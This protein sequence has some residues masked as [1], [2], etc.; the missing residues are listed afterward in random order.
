RQRRPWTLANGSQPASRCHSYSV[1]VARKSAVSWSA[2]HETT[3]SAMSMP[4]ETPDDVQNFPS[5]TQRA[6]F[7]QR[8]AGQ[9]VWGTVKNILLVVARGPSSS[10]AW[11]RSEV[12]VHTVM[13]TS[14]CAARSLS[15]AI[16]R[17]F[18]TSARVPIPPG[19]RRRS[20]GGQSVRP[21]SACT[22][23]PCALRT[24]PACSATVTT[25]ILP[26]MLPD[27]S[28]GPKRSSTS[29]SW[30]SS[31]PSVR[32]MAILLGLDATGLRARPQGH[33][34]RTSCRRRALT[35]YRRLPQKVL[36]RA[37]E[38]IGGEVVR[39]HLVTPRNPQSFWTYDHVLPAL[40]KR[41]VFPNLSMPT[42][43]GVAPCPA[44]VP[45]CDENVEEVDFDVDADLVGI[46]GYI[47][48]RDRMLELIDGFR[49][50]GKFVVV[51]GPYA[52]LCPEELR[53]CCD[54]L[55][56]DEAEETWPQFLR[57]FEAGAWRPEYRPDD[58]PDLTTAPMPRF[59]LL[60]VDRYHALTIQFAR[61]CP[62]SCEFCDIIVVYGRRP[63]AK[64]VGQVMA[65][66]A[67]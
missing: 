54:V 61:G 47:V 1:A 66:I 26:G 3:A 16:S 58:K 24:G 5:S 14:T 32:A 51:G 44:E 43:W 25:S 41:C 2:T 6:S 7:T 29:K 4:A 23:G 13:A 20:S 11:A 10:P 37:A 64:T 50:R 53:G 19:I 9:V 33:P 56:V 35:L 59:D 46:T 52:S 17:S 67:E 12:P 22:R 57:D 15:H 40:G 49:A 60:K 65:E 38:H 27:I 18:S 42:V 39:I 62:F 63:R 45:L 31:A 30:K 28:R 48:H 55:F 34:P 8:T 21:G 36:E